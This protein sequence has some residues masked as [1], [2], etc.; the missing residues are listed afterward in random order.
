V[1]LDIDQDVQIS[2]IEKWRNKPGVRGTS[3]EAQHMLQ[4][5]GAITIFVHPSAR[6]PLHAEARD[7]AT[8]T[9]F[10]N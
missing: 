3:V 4:V 10:G 2:K 5:V 9:I 7:G 6:V 8:L 1:K